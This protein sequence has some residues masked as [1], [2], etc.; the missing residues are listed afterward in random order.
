[1]LGA[2]MN[3]LNTAMAMLEGLKIGVWDWV[4]LI[5]LSLPPVFVFFSKRVTGGAKWTWFIVTSIL[6]WLGYAIF[7][8]VV[9]KKKAGSDG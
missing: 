1:M 8:A 6:S 9:R 2:D 3:D 4:L 7:L 5:V